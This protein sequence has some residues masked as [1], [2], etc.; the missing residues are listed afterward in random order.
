MPKPR[1]DARLK[2][3]P[4]HQREQLIRWLTDDNLSYADAKERLWQDM[5]VKTSTAALSQFYAT[6]CFTLRYSQAREIAETV[7]DAIATDPEKF[8]EATIAL[9]KQKAFERAVAKSGDIDELGILFKMLGDSA[10]LAIKQKELALGERRVALLEKKAA[11]ADEA[12]KI[13]RDDTLTPAQREAKMREV[14]GLK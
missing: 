12:E 8:D 6:E 13:T 11:L 10:K 2:S 5:R 1:S 4:A 3:L 14:F 7:G 9:I